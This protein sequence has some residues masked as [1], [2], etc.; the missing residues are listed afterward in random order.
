VGDYILPSYVSNFEKAWQDMEE[1][2]I[3]TYALTA[4]S[5]LQS[6][7]FLISKKSKK[8]I[9]L[10]IIVAVNTVMDILSM[11]AC[12]NTGTITKDRATTHTLLLS[13]IFSGG[14][15]VLA[16][17]RM[18]FAPSTGVTMELA[19]RSKSSEISLKIANAIH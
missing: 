7:F 11:L 3:E 13:G 14:I 2:V 15:P 6:N 5:Q 8:K 17:C 12:E 16:R 10:I 1:E 4:M 19:V 9:K 18:A